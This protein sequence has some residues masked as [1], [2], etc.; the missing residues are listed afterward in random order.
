MPVYLL[1][2][3]ELTPSMRSELRWEV[4]GV[5]IGFVLLSIGLGALGMFLFRRGTSDFTLIY[6]ASFAI[7]YAIRLLL[8]QAVI[9]WL[10]PFGDTVFNHLDLI[11][12]CFI[13]VPFTLFLAQIIEV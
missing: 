4:A 1:A 7:L 13:P 10:F 8:R 5:A 11:I 6:F 2:A 3:I 9:R 12:D